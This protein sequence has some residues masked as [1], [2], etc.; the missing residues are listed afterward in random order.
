MNFSHLCIY[1][2]II[3]THI[4]TPS[5]FYRGG[6]Y[7][8]TC[9]SSLQKDLHIHIGI[10]MC[11][12]IIIPVPVCLPNRELVAWCFVQHL[13]QT[14]NTELQNHI[15]SSPRSRTQYRP[16]SNVRTQPTPTHPLTPTPIHSHSHI[17]ISTHTHTL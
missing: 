12:I 2:S 11:L 6:H 15:A 9:I 5:Y 16:T 17:H 14:S 13:L 10:Y 8:T 7:L 4:H 3:E 1:K